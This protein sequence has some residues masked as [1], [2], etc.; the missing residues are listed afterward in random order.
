MKQYSIGEICRILSVKPHVL[1][2]WESEISLLSPKKD[3]FG[4]RIYTQR[5][6]NTLI[7]IRYLL[8]EQKYTITGAKNKIW[9]EMN[10]ESLN[11][12]AIIHS[13]R[14]DLLEISFK[15]KEWQDKIDN[16]LCK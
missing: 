11:C 12:K 2:Y 16:I 5:D 3:H 15:I 1:R 10:S 13:M 6:I 9:E 14:D 8:H 7:R 4:K